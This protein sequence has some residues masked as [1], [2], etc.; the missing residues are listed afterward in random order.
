[1]P[2][3]KLSDLDVE[4]YY[5]DSGIPKLND[6]A[7]TTLVIFHGYSFNS[8]KLPF[9]SRK[10]SHKYCFLLIDIFHRIVPIAVASHVR[11]VLVNRRGYAGST[12]F[13]PEETAPFDPAQGANA[14]V[15]DGSA[16]APSTRMVAQQYTAFLQ[17]RGI[18]IARFLAAFI[19]SEN[20]PPKSEDGSR[21]LGGISIMGWSLGN[22]VTLSMLA[23]ANTFDPILLDK[24]EPYLRKVVIYGMCF[25]DSLPTGIIIIFANRSSPSCA[26]LSNTLRSV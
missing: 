22:V 6:Q 18:E 8:R 17:Q 4:L 14:D 25:F 7:F 19:D 26:R 21:A 15:Q 24:L 2:T 13:T 11:V 3:I 10:N 9:L 12:P 23:F 20:I 16:P 5:Q 1:M